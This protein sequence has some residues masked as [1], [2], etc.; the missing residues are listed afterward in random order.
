M[1]QE[2]N[3][4]SR[5]KLLQYL[6][7]DLLLDDLRTIE[8]HVE[9]CSACKELIKELEPLS[10]KSERDKFFENTTQA[11]RI[12]QNSNSTP[13]WKDRSIFNVV[14]LVLILCEI[15]AMFSFNIF[16]FHNIKIRPTLEEIKEQIYNFSNNENVSIIDS[17]LLVTSDINEIDI[18]EEIIDEVDTSENLNENPISMQSNEL[19]TQNSNSNNEVFYSAIETVDEVVSEPISQE[20]DAITTSDESSEVVPIENEEVEIVQVKLNGTIEAMPNSEKQ[21]FPDGGFSSF[22]QYIKNGYKYP[23]VA[24]DKNIQGV[25]VAQFTLTADSN[26]TDLKIISSLSAEC[27]NLVINMIKNGP[28]WQPFVGDD[29]V[30]YRSA[31]LKFTFKL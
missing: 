21:A 17:T 15:G 29:F 16:P 12:R 22:N 11:I 5:E 30:V 24:I 9:K 13:K 25:V 3:H 14:L 8:D 19:E 7:I 4:Y 6:N 31:S 18:L 28:K 26:I 2:G 27:D 20:Q 10:N 1:T 23:D